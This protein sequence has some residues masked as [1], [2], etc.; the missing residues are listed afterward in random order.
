MARTAP[1]RMSNLHAGFASRA[2]A[3]IADMVLINVSLILVTAGA[4]TVLNY[5]DFNHIFDLGTQPTLLGRIAI[6]AVGIVTFL[7][8]Y[9]GYPVFFWVLV[10]QTPGKRLLG[11]R[12]VQKNGELLGVGQAILRAIS[13]WVSAL[14]CLWVL[15]GY[16]STTNGRDGMT[17]WLEP[18]S[19]LMPAPA[20]GGSCRRP[21]LTKK[22]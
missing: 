2:C 6:S 7:V 15:S 20:K 19:F 11:L 12:V 17:S 22:N 16:S 3:F 1:G 21:I 18:T 9:F 10:G 8:T 4:G 13:Y 5:F 14:P